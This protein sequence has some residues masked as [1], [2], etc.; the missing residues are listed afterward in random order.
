MSKGTHI[1]FRKT[2]SSISLVH[3]LTNDYFSYCKEIIDGVFCLENF[4]LF[5]NN[6][7]QNLNLF[8]NA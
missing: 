8:N 4:L 3:A 1:G 2:N 5:S 6:F 7:L